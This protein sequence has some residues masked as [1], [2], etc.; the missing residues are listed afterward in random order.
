MAKNED[1]DQMIHHEATKDTKD[2]K[3]S[4][5]SICWQECEHHLR[6]PARPSW[7]SLLFFVFFVASWW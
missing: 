6:L 3:K 7:L 2:T 4:P 1:Q 5:Q